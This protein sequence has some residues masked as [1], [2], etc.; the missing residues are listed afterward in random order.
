MSGA[1]PIVAV[2]FGGSIVTDKAGDGGI[3]HAR[4]RRIARVVAAARAA[5]AAPLV[6]IFGGGSIG[7]RAAVEH[8]LAAGAP[9]L[10]RVHRM[11]R[12]MFLLKCVL[13]RALEREGVAAMPFHET[14]LL[15]AEGDEVRLQPLALRRAVETGMVPILSGGPVYA[16][17]GSLIPFNSDRLGAALHGSGA[18]E[19][20]RFILYSDSPGVV[21]RDGAII[22]VLGRRN[23]A[24]VADIG[25]APGV[26]DISGGMI[27]KVAI[28]LDLAE[29]GVE[30]VICG[31]EALDAGAFAEMVSGAGW[32]GT[33]LTG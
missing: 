13:A 28:A 14:S 18:F 11:A 2:K 16:A 33:R 24:D 27:E 8:G 21:G 32:R 12:A 6:L 3:R 31:V 29:R 30:C 9:A 22:P 4:I 5:S 17:P 20:R 15:L 25:L 26:T 23:L 10:G 19:V 7:H 1:L